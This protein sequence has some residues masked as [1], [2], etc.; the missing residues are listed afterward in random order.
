VT[1]QERIAA[2][3][4]L[5]QL[6]DKAF[7]EGE[8][9]V[10]YPKGAVNAEQQAKSLHESLAAYRGKIRKNQLQNLEEWGRISNVSLIKESDRVVLLQ[11]KGL[12]ARSRIR[13]VL[14]LPNA[15]P[16]LGLSR[17]NGGPPGLSGIIGE[18]GRELDA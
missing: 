13:E 4:V 7:Y 2:D 16:E 5:R 17:G 18:F 15:M 9:R 6:W 10:E 14:N 3:R 12:H 8:V 11:K 1:R